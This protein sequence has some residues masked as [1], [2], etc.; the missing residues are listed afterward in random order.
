MNKNRN[1]LT[2]LCIYCLMAV[3]FISAVVIPAFAQESPASPQPA[4]SSAPGASPAPVEKNTTVAKETNFFSQ[5]AGW[6]IGLLIA[7]PIIIIVLIFAF[8]Y[9]TGSMGEKDGD[10]I[11]QKEYPRQARQEKEK[12][13]EAEKAK[14][15]AKEEAKSPEQ[16]KPKKTGKRIPVPLTLIDQKQIAREGALTSDFYIKSIEGANKGEVFKI[17]KYVS[18]MGRRSRDGRL[19]DI[20]LSSYEK[21]VSR[22]QALIL[23]K[24]DDDTYYLIN[25][26]DAAMK[27]N[28]ER[29]NS[30]AAYP[31]YEGDKIYMGAGSVVLQF[32]R[33]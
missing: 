27:V 23:Y 18:T 25:E 1:R 24:K 3:L 17:G 7:A 12:Q 22:E 2:I 21:Q 26:S 15:T 28:A 10:I 8:T 9:I 5:L 13:K 19:N 30:T 29:V 14:E 20:E 16:R 11:D 4:V 32:L 31:L 33:M 6:Q